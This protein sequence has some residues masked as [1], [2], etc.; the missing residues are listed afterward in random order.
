MDSKTF[1][2]GKLGSE[3]PDMPI[4]RAPAC[5]KA[6][7]HVKSRA[8]VKEDP[9]FAR[10]YMA[11]SGLVVAVGWSSPTTFAMKL[12][13]SSAAREAPTRGVV[14]C[15]RRSTDAI[16]SIRKSEAGGC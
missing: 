16:Q 11:R 14:A 15:S 10:L 12:V 7:G 6:G 3:H 9:A 8:A 5:M 13:D 1:L 4:C 2:T